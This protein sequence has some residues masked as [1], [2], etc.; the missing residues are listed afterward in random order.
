MS[1]SLNVP[2]GSEL[3]TKLRSAIRNRYDM[4]ENEMSK[5]YEAWKD[6]EERFIAYRHV[7]EN[8][9]AREDARDDGRPQFTTIEIPYS[10]A[11]LMTAQTYWTTVFLG[12]SPVFQ[13]TAR[14][15]EAQNQ[16]LGIEALMDYQLMVGE[17]MVPLYIWLLDQGKYGLGIVCNYWDEQE[18]VVSSIENRP[19]TYLGIPVPGKT[20]RI[21]TSKRISGYKGNKLFNVKPFDFKPDPRVP[22]KDFQKG[23]FCARDVEISWNEIIR[24]EASGKY[25][26]IKAL[27]DN[28]RSK[29][30]N[31]DAEY[32]TDQIELPVKNETADAMDN[33]FT[34][35]VEMFVELIPN[36]WEMGSSKYPE[37]WIFTLASDEIIIEARPMGN[38]H[39]KFPFQVQE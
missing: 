21:R 27:R 1:E 17:M 29:Q 32:S 22:I 34:T 30:L 14:H 3:H 39:G 4:S 6:A 37:K 12:R 20:E 13:Y 26:N 9:Q 10:Y 2:Y 8:D 15:G 19:V 5:Y 38:Y 18:V 36:E 7:T 35:G 16:V 33:G 31:E 24:G 11:M 25:F 28:I 23:E